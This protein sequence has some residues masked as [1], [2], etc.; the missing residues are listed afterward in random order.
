MKNRTILITGSSRGIGKEIALEFSKKG[1]NL[2]INY[3]ENEGAAKEVLTQISGFCNCI[4]IKADVSK[5]SDVD[6]LFNEAIKNFGFVDTVVN[7]AG[8]V[9][10]GLMTDMSEKDY[11]YIMNTNLK[12]AYL[13][14]KVFLP[15]MIEN[16]FGRIIN[17]SSILGA[18][19]AS[20][21]VIYS[22]SKAGMIGLT[23]ALAKEV[24][25]CGITVNAVAPGLIE[26]DMTKDLDF[27]LLAD[28]IVTG[29]IGK[30]SDIAAAVSF[31][32]GSEAEYVNGQVLGV[33]GG[34]LI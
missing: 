19:G 3:K 32:A 20:C 22:A 18:N 24:G 2:V 27:G 17:I 30:P 21:E 16:R 33:D 4:L 26:T 15:R 23:K 6:R 31:L 29:R 34:F 10:S 13:V 28:R 8:V 11:D 25:G 14:S 1:Y 12:G 7:N 5:Q 9:L